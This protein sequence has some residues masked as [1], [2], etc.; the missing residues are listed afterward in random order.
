MSS[1]SNQ[2][3]QM[4]QV[5]ARLQALEIANQSLTEENAKMKKRASKNAGKVKAHKE[6]IVKEKKVAKP[7]KNSGGANAHVNALAQKEGKLIPFRMGGCACRVWGNGNG[8]QC[9]RAAM[10]GRYCAMHLKKIEENDGWFIGDYD[11]LRPENWSE[12]VGRTGKSQAKSQFKGCVWKMPA[13]LYIPA[14]EAEFGSLGAT[15]PTPPTPPVRVVVEEDSASDL[16]IAS[17][18]SLTQAYAPDV[19]NMAD[20]DE[21][22]EIVAVAPVSPVFDVKEFVGNIIASAIS[23]R[24]MPSVLMLEDAPAPPATHQSFQELLS[25]QTWDGFTHDEIVDMCGSPEEVEEYKASCEKTDSECSGSD[26]TL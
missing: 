8:T 18:R 17:T 2:Q 10:D 11:V 7:K 19:A 25:Q 6:K 15:A 4:E 13:S 26:M 5:L 9:S 16:S 3:T 24:E 21:D 20:F 1:V 22:Y 14:F 12:S 23:K